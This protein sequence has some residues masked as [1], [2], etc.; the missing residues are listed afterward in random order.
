[1]C[2][3]LFYFLFYSQTVF[4]PGSGSE[5]DRLDGSCSRPGQRQVLS[6][7]KDRS[8]EE[9]TIVGK[10]E[11]YEKKRKQSL[12]EQRTVNNT[13]NFMD[14]TKNQ[15]QR[16][17]VGPSFCLFIHILHDYHFEEEKIKAKKRATL[18]EQQPKKRARRLLL[19]ARA[20]PGNLQGR[21][22]RE[23]S[24]N[25]NNALRNCSLGINR[26]HNL[27]LPFLSKHSLHGGS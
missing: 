6:K 2:R 5:L 19:V 18:R 23:Q 4:V 26:L 7:M 20:I 13:G 21:F 16:T 11:G 12:V 8:E 17:I 14:R 3:F 22:L 24:S 27:L 9:R 10:E 1:M 25:R 15:Q